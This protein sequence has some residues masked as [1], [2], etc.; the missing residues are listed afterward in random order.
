[1]Q[2]HHN[3]SRGQNAGY[4]LM[5]DLPYLM[6]QMTE[7]FCHTEEGVHAFLNVLRLHLTVDPGLVILGAGW[8]FVDSLYLLRALKRLSQNT[9]CLRTAYM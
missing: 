1:M 4:L 3:M 2:E 5:K 9:C 7:L 8:S 6:E